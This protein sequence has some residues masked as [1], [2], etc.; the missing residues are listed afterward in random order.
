MTNWGSRFGIARLTESLMKGDDKNR[1]LSNSER[2]LCT[3]PRLD[4]G[5]S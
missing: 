4:L 2:I 1:K 5:C 3:I